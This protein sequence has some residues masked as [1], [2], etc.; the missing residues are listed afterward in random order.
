MLAKFRK[1]KSFRDS[2]TRA[3]WRK[4]AIV[5]WRVKD[6]SL[7]ED[8][9]PVYETNDARFDE[10]NRLTNR[11]ERLAYYVQG[12][13]VHTGNRRYPQQVTHTLPYSL[14]KSVKVLK[15]G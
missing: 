14:V 5:A 11:L 10:F 9:A 3:L 1:D 2:V 13:L 12:E 4:R 6:W 7:D 8:K 15:N